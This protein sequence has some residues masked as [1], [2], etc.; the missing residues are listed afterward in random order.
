MFE[1]GA[2]V[3]S[4]KG[5]EWGERLFCKNCGSSL[6]WQAHDGKNQHVSIQC[7]EDPAAFELTAEIFVESKP[8]N[9]ALAGERQMITGEELRKMFASAPEG[10][11]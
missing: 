8:A 10:D 4:Y 11:A 3:G 2:P 1:E 9:Y 7:F 6:L 5:S